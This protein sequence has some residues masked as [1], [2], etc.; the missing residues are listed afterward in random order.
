MFRHLAQMAADRFAEQQHHAFEVGTLKPP[1]VTAN[2]GSAE[3]LTVLINA[4]EVVFCVVSI[5]VVL[6]LAT[7]VTF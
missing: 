2:A 3:I 7:I 6:L 4:I 1:F 5:A